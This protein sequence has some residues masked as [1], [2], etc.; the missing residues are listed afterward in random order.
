MKA[1]T[2]SSSSCWSSAKRAALLGGGQSFADITFDVSL[3][4]DTW[5]LQPAHVYGATD[6]GRFY[7]ISRISATAYVRRRAGAR[8]T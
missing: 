7:L 8:G 4:P 2:G 1:P 3:M 6:N 5:S